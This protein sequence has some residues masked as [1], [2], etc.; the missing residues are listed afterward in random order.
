MTG[1]PGQ[2]GANPAEA[3]DNVGNVP[4][5]PEA[6]GNLRPPEPPPPVSSE[7]SAPEPGNER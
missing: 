4:T 1:A 6:N 2:P 5:P 7:S 3:Q